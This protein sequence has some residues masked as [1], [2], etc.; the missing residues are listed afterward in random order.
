MSAKLV[1]GPRSRRRLYAVRRL[2]VVRGIL[3][4][5][6]LL[7]VYQA[8]SGEAAIRAARRD[9]PSYAREVLAA[10][11]QIA[12]LLAIGGEALLYLVIVQ[13]PDGTTR[14]ILLS[15]NGQDHAFRG[16]RLI[17]NSRPGDELHFAAEDEVE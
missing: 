9:F 17:R 5:G 1:F 6:P 16:I 10:V 4:R 2:K 8:T 14:K 13:C 11:D 12:S 3:A 15:H 7:G